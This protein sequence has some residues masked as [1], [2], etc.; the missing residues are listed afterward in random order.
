MLK[1]S[2]AL[3]VGNLD[4]NKYF[5]IEFG[6]CQRRGQILDEE[7]PAQTHRRLGRPRTGRRD[8]SQHLRLFFEERSHS[9]S[10]M[11]I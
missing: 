4:A 6:I 2:G 7:N 11:V 9:F 5:C 10:E 1:P 3:Q 8:G